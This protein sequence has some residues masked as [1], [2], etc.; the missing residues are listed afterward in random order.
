[1]A[2]AMAAGGLATCATVLRVGEELD[3]LMPGWVEHAAAQISGHTGE[4]ISCGLRRACLLLASRPLRDP[5]GLIGALDLPAG[6]PDG[7]FWL[8]VALAGT[9]TVDARRAW[10]FHMRRLC[11]ERRPGA[12]PAL[13]LAF[14]RPL[15]GGW[16]TWEDFRLCVGDARVLAH[17]T[18]ERGYRGALQRL[19]VWSHP[20]FAKWYRQLVY[21]I[22]HQ[23]DAALS[24]HDSGWVKDFPGEEYLW[25]ALE[26][27]AREPDSWWHLHVLRWVSDVEIVS[28]RVVSQLA[29]IQPVPL[30][31]VSL[32]RPDFA[33]S[34]GFALGAP[35]HASAIA[36]LTQSTPSQAPDSRWVETVFAQWISAIGDAF[37]Q[38][39][40]ALCSLSLPSDWQAC[41]GV[42]PRAAGS[43]AERRRA[44]LLEHLVPEF[45][46]LMDNVP[47]LYALSKQHF[48]VIASHAGKG[49]PA[50]L[51]ALGFWPEMAEEAAP[52]LLRLRREG[53][54]TTRQ[55]AEQSLAILS[56]KAGVPDISRLEKRVDLAAAWTHGGLEDGPTRVSWDIAGYRVGI[57]ISSGG[58]GIEVH[59]GDRRLTSIPAAVRKDGAFAEVR[60]SRARLAKCYRYFRHRLEQ[61]MVDQSGYSAA[62]LSVLMANP[63]VR[64]LFARLAVTVN[65]VPLR[66]SYAAPRMTGGGPVAEHMLP[67]EVAAAKEIRIAHPIDL[68]RLGALDE[69]QQ[70]VVDS[71]TPQPFK[72]V[73]REV[74]LAGEAEKDSRECHRFA[75]HRLAARRAYALLRARGYSVAENTATREWPRHGVTACLCW[76][77]PG[78]DAG[79]ALGQ[80]GDAGAVTSGPVWFTDERGERIALRAVP[81]VML[82]ETL[83]DADLLVSWAAAGELG[84]T[85]EETRRLR[86][87]LV[88]YLARALGLTCVYVGE[89]CVHVLVEGQRATYRL[90]LGSG[91]VV[92]EDS[93]RSLDLTS[94]SSASAEALV[95]ESVDAITSRIVSLVVM[96]SHDDQITDPGFLSSLRSRASS[97][98]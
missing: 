87:T 4:A 57:C 30:C 24:F 21:E 31:L 88:R 74:Y 36:W 47:Y 61:A 32:V 45:D 41:P 40:G 62:E 83:R 39:V 16:L 50:A 54:K 98:E 26:G 82:S 59:S 29:A 96:L 66:W 42:R 35:E 49:R 18:G 90:H 78:E 27:L 38:A 58:V 65:G 77:S 76:A 25:D 17:A 1:M 72:Q 44:F 55:A 22:A 51:R 11:A 64:S 91:S 14:V 33:H 9:D 3:R 97:A 92:L 23:P 53:N 79:R 46:R 5:S 94:L 37:M 80:P 13:W 19:G 95:A 71:R 56:S 84:F 93:R 85:S 48:P 15:L 69:W 8:L 43:E 67:P 68:L 10:L 63:V 6:D 73:F 86:G 75:G 28:E 12:G 70:Q 89:D 34:A 20:T 7:G 81:P 52:I 60:E 2:T